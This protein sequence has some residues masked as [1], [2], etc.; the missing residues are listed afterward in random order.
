MT[1]ADDMTGGRVAAFRNTGTGIQ[2][3]TMCWGC[4]LPKSQLGGGYI[5]RLKLFHCATCKQIKDAARSVR[6]ARQTEVTT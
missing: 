3:T 1:D 5:G 2:P 6:V 4:N